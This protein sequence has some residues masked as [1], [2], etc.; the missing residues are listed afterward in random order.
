MRAVMK[1]IDALKFKEYKFQPELKSQLYEFDNIHDEG[2]L[3]K[4]KIVKNISIFHRISQKGPNKFELQNPNY[5]MF[6][7][8]N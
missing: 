7:L 8:E 3:L 5:W 6:Y 2:K 1:R 4:N